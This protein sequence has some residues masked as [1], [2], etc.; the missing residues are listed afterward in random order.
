[1][2]PAC[3]HGQGRGSCVPPAAESVP[4]FNLHRGGLSAL[5]RA[6]RQTTPLFNLHRMGFVLRSQKR[7]SNP[8]RQTTPLFNLH[9]MGFDMRSQKRIS[10]PIRQTTPLFNLHALLNGHCHDALLD[11]APACPCP[12]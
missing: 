4:V 5:H 9:R 3:C 6:C 8:I 1:M 12:A 7:I 11:P 10:N 2:R